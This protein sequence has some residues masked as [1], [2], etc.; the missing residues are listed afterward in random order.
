MKKHIFQP[1]PFA[2]GENR[3]LLIPSG[4]DLPNTL[5]LPIGPCAMMCKIQSPRS[6]H[7]SLKSGSRTLS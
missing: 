7:W 5:L 1:T 6:F 4:D 2:L 3:H